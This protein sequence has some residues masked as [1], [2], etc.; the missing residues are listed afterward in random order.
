MT[1]A[2][3]AKPGHGEACEALATAPVARDEGWRWLARI[4]R[5]LAVVAEEQDDP[6]LVIIQAL[7]AEVQARADQA[8]QKGVR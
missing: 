5:H 6:R 7:R 4:V 1:A 2:E 8:A 3:F